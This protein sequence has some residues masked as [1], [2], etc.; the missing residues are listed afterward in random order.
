[1]STPE[2]LVDAVDRLLDRMFEE[3]PVTL[4]TWSPAFLE[5]IELTRLAYLRERQLRGE[6]HTDFP[7]VWEVAA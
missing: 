1:M 2:S 6:F 7:Q 4:P 5:A 3:W